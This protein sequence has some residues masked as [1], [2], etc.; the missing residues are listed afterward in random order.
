MWSR[1]RRW[2][3]WVTTMLVIGVYFTIQSA[4]EGSAR[5]KAG[6]V[7]GLCLGV[8]YLAEE[9]FW[10][11]KRQGHPCGHCSQKVQLKAFRVKLTCPHCG[12]PL[13]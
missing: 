13:E 8:A 12:Q 4:P 2:K 5:W 11:V 9:V 3:S 6:I 7:I 1:Y 10:M